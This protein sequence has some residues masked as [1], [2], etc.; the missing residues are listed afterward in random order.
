M[1][2][3]DAL[4]RDLERCESFCFIVNS[5]ACTFKRRLVTFA[6][7]PSALPPGGRYISRDGLD[8]GVDKLVLPFC[9]TASLIVKSV[10]ESSFPRSR[11]ERKLRKS[12]FSRTDHRD[13]NTRGH[14]GSSG[15]HV[16]NTEMNFPAGRVSLSRREARLFRVV[17]VVVVS[18]LVVVVVV[19]SL[20]AHAEVPLR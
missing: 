15:T 4:I 18:L 6:V 19:A 8:L 1:E 5:L 12:L 20:L 16:Q 2:R 14:T 11:T 10:R 7:V 13:K 17:V 3:S 9:G